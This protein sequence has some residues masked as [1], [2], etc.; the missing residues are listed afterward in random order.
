MSF[1]IQ[2]V[3]PQLYAN[4]ARGRGIKKMNSVWEGVVRNGREIANGDGEEEVTDGRKD[5]DV[6][7]LDDSIIDQQ[8]GRGVKVRHLTSPSPRFC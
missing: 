7:L 4:S 5:E 1:K 8:P 2:E 6:R 3:F